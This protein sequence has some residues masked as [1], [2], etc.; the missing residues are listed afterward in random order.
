MENELEEFIEDLSK[1]HCDFAL[2]DDDEEVQEVEIDW[3][4][5]NLQ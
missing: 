1:G 2:E 3:S 5:N 4:L